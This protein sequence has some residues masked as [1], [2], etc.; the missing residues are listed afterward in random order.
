LSEAQKAL[1]IVTW[2]GAVVAMLQVGALI[3]GV[4]TLLPAILITI[5]IYLVITMLTLAILNEIETKVA[6]RRYD[7]EEETT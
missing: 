7:D 3:G 6:Y 4:F 1:E 2:L 5:S